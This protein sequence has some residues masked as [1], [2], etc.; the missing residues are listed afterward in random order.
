MLKRMLIFAAVVVAVV[1]LAPAADFTQLPQPL[2]NA[3]VGQWVSYTVMGG[4]EQKQSITGIEGSGDEMTI[5]MTIESIM[6]G[7]VLQSQ[8]MPVNLA[9]AKEM[10]QA[11][12]ADNPDVVIREE[13]VTVNGKSYDALVVE[14]DTP[15]GTTKTYMSHEIPV[16]GLLKAEMGD[17]VMM[18][19]SGYGE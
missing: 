6:G 14:V 10:E 17:M 4:S 18:E 8:E 7:H 9:E 1:S 11:L 5:I 15:N 13:T 2:D 19:L 3:K 16:T 12:R